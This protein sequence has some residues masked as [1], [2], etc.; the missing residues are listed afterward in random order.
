MI[1]CCTQS[2]NIVH[3]CISIFELRETF[4]VLH[5]FFFSST[6]CIESETLFGNA[7]IK[8]FVANFCHPGLEVIDYQEKLLRSN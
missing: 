7:S 2:R 6:F 4:R 8:R 1:Q 3:V 5:I